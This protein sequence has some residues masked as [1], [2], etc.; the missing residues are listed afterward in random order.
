MRFLSNPTVAAV[1]AAL[2][3]A[4]LAVVPVENTASAQPRPNVILINL[5]DADYDL[6]DD[7]AL[8]A[9]FPNIATHLRDDGLRLD[10]LHVST[11]LCGPSRAAL[12]RSQYAH[13]T[14]VLTNAASSEWPGGFGPSYDGGYTSD[15]LGMWMQDAG[16]TTMLVGKYLHE[17][18]PALSGDNRYQPPG[19][20]EFMATRGGKY[21]NFTQLINGELVGPTLDY[22]RQFRTD[23][24]RLEAVGLLRDHV[25]EANPMFLYLAP[26]APH[27]SS[28]TPIHA[29]RHAGLFAEAQVPRTPDFN[30]AD[31]SD[32]P[33]QISQLPTY[34]GAGL[35]AMD[36]LYRRRLRSMMAVDEMV[37][38]LV[39][40]LDALGQLDNTY[41]MLTSDNGFSLGH[42]RLAAKA[43]PYDRMTR[44]GML[45][46]GPGIPAGTEAHHLLSHIDIA[47]TVVDLADGT[48]PDWVDGQSFAPVLFDP[49]GVPLSRARSWIGVEGWGVKNQRG[50]QLDA[51]FSAIR[52]RDRIYVEWANG[53]REFY[54]LRTDPYQL[55]NS[56]DELQATE[57]GRLAELA[58]RVNGCVGPECNR[59]RVGNDPPETRVTMP[60]DETPVRSTLKVR[61]KATDDRAIERVEI[62]VRTRQGS[63]Y[64]NGTHF[65]N[66]YASVEAK[67]SRPGSRTT[68]FWTRLTVPNIDLDIFARAYDGDGTS[69]PLVEVI[70][71]NETPDVI[72][73]TVE[74]TSPTAGVSVTGPLVIAGTAADDFE[75]DRVLVVIKDRDTNLFW[76]GQQFVPTFSRVPADLGR[77]QR[78]RTPFRYEVDLQAGTYTVSAR[79][80]DS[81]GNFTDPPALAT[82]TLTP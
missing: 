43:L 17:G 77:P 27:E 48:V 33:A 36:D 81:S 14:G 9:Y 78:P 38:G 44:V 42:N 62:I 63:R 23:I 74:M 79:A 26:F 32:K 47:P 8:D 55:A 61:G 31:M 45:V 54:D 37:G 25:G 70:R 28:S 82:V 39:S 50:V 73:P 41:I 58:Q 64:W 18:F 56:Y 75:V 35:E 52:G 80:Y 1:V 65:Q 12:L 20:D 22:P 29:A 2:L 16:Y 11:A 72:P 34:T 4:S 40:E 66:G 76:D 21:Y 60:D 24:E 49:T 10:N 3:A 59:Q 68:R 6:I 53:D 5:D 30:E 71:Q 57:R 46:R 7:P 51:T 19:W 69:D 15:E 67:I 13:N